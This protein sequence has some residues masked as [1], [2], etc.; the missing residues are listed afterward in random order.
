MRAEFVSLQILLSSV[1]KM[2][3]I[4]NFGFHLFEGAV[5]AL[6]LFMIGTMVQFPGNFSTKIVLSGSMEPT[7][8]IGSLVIIKPSV[9][10]KIGDVIT[11]GD[12]SKNDIPTTHRV[13]EMRVD[14]GEMVYVTKGDANNDR[15]LQEVREDEV[16]GKVLVNIPYLGYVI[17]LA[18]KPLGMV[19]LIIIPALIVILDEVK[20]IIR[21]VRRIWAKKE[22]EHRPPIF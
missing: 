15:D 13:V 3:R 18:R 4:F 21:E 8:P 16:I 2:Q 22:R 12:D 14:N 17:D 1:N 7:I 19:F 9:S 20:K 10:Y 11:F 5:I 6:A